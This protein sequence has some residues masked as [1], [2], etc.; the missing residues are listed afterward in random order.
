MSDDKKTEKPLK[1]PEVEVQ[2]VPK[3]KYDKEH[4]E[5]AEQLE[6]KVKK[7]VEK[8]IEENKSGGKDKQFKAAEQETERAAESTGNEKIEQINVRVDGDDEAGNHEGRDWSKKPKEG[9]PTP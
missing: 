5:A 6:E 7:N 3:N 1:D 2:V 8:A 9:K 4:T